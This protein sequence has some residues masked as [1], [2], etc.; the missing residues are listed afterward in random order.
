MSVVRSEENLANEPAGWD[1]ETLRI[2]EQLDADNERYMMVNIE[3]R[4]LLEEAVWR[5]V[6]LE[7][8]V[9]ALLAE[10][11]SGAAEIESLYVER[12]SLYVE[13]GSLYAERDSLYAERDSSHNENV[14]LR[15]E[16]VTVRAQLS[17]AEAELKAL[18][19]TK[20]MRVAA[21]FRSLYARARRFHG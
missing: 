7:R 11:A 9:D 1:D 21:P 3:L 20:L 18:Y 13:R 15:D 10:V 14:A 4:D 19:N 6:G 2:L 8:R 16:I 17:R 5:E 12:G